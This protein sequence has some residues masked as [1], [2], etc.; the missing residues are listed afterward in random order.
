MVA[1]L[2]GNKVISGDKKYSEVPAGLKTAVKKYLISKGYGHLAVED[3][4]ETT[5]PVNNE[6]V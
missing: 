6:P 1:R 4:T 5:E 2:W 3:E